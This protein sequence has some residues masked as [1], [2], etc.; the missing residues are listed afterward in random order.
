M[1]KKDVSTISNSVY[2][3]I[4]E[5][6]DTI[7]DS[8]KQVDARNEPIKETHIVDGINNL[9]VG[10]VSVKPAVIGIGIIGQGITQGVINGGT[11]IGSNL[12]T[13][14]LTNS[15]EIIFDMNKFQLNTLQ[16]E[17]FVIGPQDESVEINRK[18]ICASSDSRNIRG[19][20][21]S[22]IDTPGA[23][24]EIRGPRSDTT[25]NVLSCT[26]SIGN[27]TCQTH[28][29]VMTLILPMTVITDASDAKIRNMGKNDLIKLCPTL[30][31]KLLT[32]AYKSNIIRF[33]M[34]EDPLQR[35]IYFLTFAELLEMIFSQYTENCQVILDYPRI[36]G[37]DVIEDHSKKAIRT[38]FS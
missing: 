28:L 21:I 4:N 22:R 38:L 17:A 31:E 35:R 8:S 37:D 12:A 6:I 11:N 14:V 7:S 27:M 29:Q 10:V 30:T 33:K 32:T 5:H 9:L 34:N 25:S 26:D 2:N 13:N 18:I 23:N 16:S 15:S 20:N 19:N 24:E 36:G 3:E 1:K